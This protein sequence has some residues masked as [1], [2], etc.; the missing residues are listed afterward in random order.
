MHA[1]NAYTG[2]Y[3]TT[4]SPTVTATLWLQRQYQS[5]YGMFAYSS[6]FF[7]R[8]CAL[9]SFPSEIE[10]VCPSA[11]FRKPTY[12]VYVYPWLYICMYKFDRI[13]IALQHACICHFPINRATSESAVGDIAENKG[14]VNRFDVEIDK[15]N[16]YMYLHMYLC[17]HLMREEGKC[18][19]RLG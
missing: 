12:G 14:L 15:T 2:V 4:A 7:K 6:F 16:K 8:S 3:N 18:A 11:F 1:F 19:V 10:N 5:T 17:R 9:K 13:N